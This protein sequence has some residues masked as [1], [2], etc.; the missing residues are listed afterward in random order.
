MDIDTM[1]SEYIEARI[2]AHH[3]RTFLGHKEEVLEDILQR[4][5]LLVLELGIEKMAEIEREIKERID[6]RET[7]HD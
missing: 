3:N 4:H 7:H 1:K 2:M 6:G 5:E